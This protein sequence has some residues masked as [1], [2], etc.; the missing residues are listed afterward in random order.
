MTMYAQE[1]ASTGYVMQTIGEVDPPGYTGPV[2]PPPVME[3]YVFHLLAQP[4]DWSGQP[5]PTC[6]MAW[7][8]GA[9]GWVETQPLADTVAQARS[10]IDTKADDA[11]KSV[12]VTETKDLEYKR[13]ETVARP[14]R[15]ASY[16]PPVPDAVQSWADAKRWANG[17]VP[18]TA[19]QAADDI[20]A[21]ADR[22]NGLLDGI[23]KLRLDAMEHC[24]AIGNDPAGTHAQVRAVE[25]QFN[26]DLAALMGQ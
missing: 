1:E 16:T 15:D 22:Y 25:A 11:R 13:A 5:S 26:A 17:G 18:W 23:R 2:E 4:M 14:F 7:N 12:L 3:G 19:Q 10:R 24:M 9:Y 6:R 21:A 20:L 8:G